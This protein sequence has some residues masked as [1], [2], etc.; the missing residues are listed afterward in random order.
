[1]RTNLATGEITQYR[2]DHRNRLTSVTT[3]D[4]PAGPTT[5][6]VHHRYDVSN[7]WISTQLDGD[8]DGPSPPT[9]TRYDYDGNQIVLERTESGEVSKRYSWGVMIDQIM[10]EEDV[11]TDQVFYPLADHLGS[12]RDITDEAGQV[13]NH[14]QYDSYGNIENETDA[15]IDSL[16]GYSGRPLDQAT[17]LQNNHHRWYDAPLGR[18]ISE[19]PVSFA[20]ADTN[21]NRYVANSPTN[22]VDPSGRV[23]FFVHGINN[24]NLDDVRA[25]NEQ[26]AGQRE[27]RQEIVHFV[28]GR[29]RDATTGNRYPNVPTS[30]DAVLSTDSKLNKAAGEAFAELVNKTQRRI[31]AMGSNEPIHVVL[32]SNGS[33]PG[34]IAAEHFRKPVDSLTFIGASL[35]GHVTDLRPVAANTVQL[36]NLVSPADGG[37]K[38]VK[39]MG[40]RGTRS[41]YVDLANFHE[42]SI[43]NVFHSLNEANSSHPYITAKSENRMPG[44]VAPLTMGWAYDFLQ[45]GK[46]FQDNGGGIIYATTWLTRYMA[47]KYYA[48]IVQLADGEDNRFSRFGTL[49]NGA[50]M[51]KCDQVPV[52]YIFYFGD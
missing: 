51:N 12:V 21:L 9:L 31:D 46:S 2:W 3:R 43:P 29:G 42:Y 48:P 44:H 4:F 47:T 22:A 27:Q 40:S 13:V 15:A 37:T 10:A 26:L 45:L 49:P 36:Y 17:G 7:R 52:E 5:Q 28:Y 19:D 23:I 6:T 20:G 39:G 50:R 38:L 18:W 8:G 16:F 30:M 11:A 14:I 1:V 25:I 34:T 33:N 32:Y 41:R 24:K 35:R